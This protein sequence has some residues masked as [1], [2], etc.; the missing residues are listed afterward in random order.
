MFKL[1][2]PIIIPTRKLLVLSFRS[3]I[4]FEHDQHLE[5]FEHRC[6]RRGGWRGFQRAGDHWYR[7][8]G[9][10]QG[11]FAVEVEQAVV[12]PG[13]GHE[14]D[15]RRVGEKKHV[16]MLLWESRGQTS[17]KNH[18]MRWYGL[19]DRRFESIWLVALTR[20]ISN[21]SRTFDI[22]LCQCLTP[23]CC[24]LQDIFFYITSVLLLFFALHDGVVS[25]EDALML[26]LGRIKESQVRCLKLQQEGMVNLGEVQI[27]LWSWYSNPFTV[28]QIWSHGGHSARCQKARVSS[29]SWIGSDFGCP[30]SSEAFVTSCQWST[31]AGD[32]RQWA[33]D[34]KVA[35]K[36]LIPERMSLAGCIYKDS[37]AIK[38]TKGLL[39][40]EDV[41]S[42]Y[43]LHLEVENC[44]DL[45]LH[46]NW[47][48]TIQLSIL[49]TDIKH[50]FCPENSVNLEKNNRITDGIW[51]WTPSTS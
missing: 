39:Q 29:P 50:I 40:W 9:D 1:D 17:A 12:L 31:C 41:Y 23:S 44:R 20:N 30:G 5:T 34:N 47:D 37:K 36:I 51:R 14:Q 16:I 38:K 3:R 45:F 2:Y 19:L 7:G 15:K 6:W 33:Q 18:C 25:S 27:F 48:I 8:A 28:G 35:Q 4:G 42:P 32:V 13:P 26:C 10:A 46:D 43:S 11:I 22:S 24:G 21:F 49:Y